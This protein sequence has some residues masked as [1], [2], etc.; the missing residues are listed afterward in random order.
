MKIVHSIEELR[1]LILAYKKQGETVGLVPTM[2]FLH[3]GHMSLVS[4]AKETCSKV[5]MSIFVNPLQFGPNEDFEKYPRNIERDSEMAKSHGVDILFTPSVEEMYPTKALTTVLVSG[6]TSRLCGSSRPGHFDGVATVVTKL[7]NIVQPHYA[8]FG[9]KDAQ[10][11]AV[12]E[13]MVHD[14]NMPIEIVPCEIV[15]EE[16]GLALSSRNVYLN[17]EERDQALV[18]SAA[19]KQAAEDLKKGISAEQVRTR[20]IQKIE[21]KPLAQIDYVELLNYPELTP[22]AECNGN[23][24]ILALAVKFGNTRLIDNKIFSREGE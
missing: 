19:L 11:V 20:V 12:I 9:L 15:R 17:K 13:Q 21:S 8:F 7:F 23:P 22:V 3:Q 4:R 5:V 18:L 1:T 6:I 10:Q 24:I 14:L 16:D 2:G